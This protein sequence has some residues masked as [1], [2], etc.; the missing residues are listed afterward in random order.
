MAAATTALFLSASAGA[1]HS[2]AVLYQLDKEVNVEGTVTRFT[3][4]NP[5][6]RI[7]MMVQDEDGNESEWM[8]EGGSRTVLL[9]NGWSAEDV[10]PG[11]VVTVI[12]N[13]SRDGSPIIHWEKVVLPDGTER[14]GEDIPEDSVLEQL[15]Q[16]RR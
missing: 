5:H 9:R 7:Y 10:K 8:A 6:A 2:A 1:H 12:G 15:R 13:P 3:L 16:R 14:W 4:G 11:D